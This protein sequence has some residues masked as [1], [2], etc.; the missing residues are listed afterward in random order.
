MTDQSLWVVRLLY[1]IHVII[2]YKGLKTTAVKETFYYMQWHI[3]VV[4]TI[5][6]SLFFIH[7][8][9][10]VSGFRR[11]RLWVGVCVGVWVWELIR[12]LL[13]YMYV[14]K[15]ILYIFCPVLFNVSLMN[16]LIHWTESHIIG[17]C[18]NFKHA[19]YIIGTDFYSI[20][21]VTSRTRRSAIKIVEP[22][23]S[24][25]TPHPA[26]IRIHN[27]LRLEKDSL[28]FGNDMFIIGRILE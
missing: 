23:F 26:T 13:V 10:D 28:D 5:V 2:I 20:E 25:T 22:P 7:T 4:N 12:F 16:Y 6:I 11:S 27:V 21:P 18:Y 14:I 8:Y 15:C 19:N 24:K 3:S 9:N 1:I 17:V